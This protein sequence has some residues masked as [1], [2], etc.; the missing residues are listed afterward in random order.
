MTL[1]TPIATEMRETQHDHWND[2]GNDVFVDGRPCDAVFS[3]RCG[4]RELH[5]TREAALARAEKFLADKAKG[6]SVSDA[7]ILA[8]LGA[9]SGPG[10]RVHHISDRL[11]LGKAAR[12]RITRRLLAMERKGLVRR[13]ER[14]SFANSYY[15]EIVA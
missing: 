2:A 12:P 6:F 15:W 7:R 11:G 5:P 10:G 1:I 8:A 4:L 14:H 13:S 3:T 9:L